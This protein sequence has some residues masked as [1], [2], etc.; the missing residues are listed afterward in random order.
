LII[1]NFAKYSFD[2]RIDYQFYNEFL[3]DIGGLEVEDFVLENIPDEDLSTD[4]WYEAVLEG[5]D[6]KYRVWISEDNSPDRSGISN[7]GL[8]IAEK[9]PLKIDSGYTKWRR[10]K[11]T[12]Y[13]GRNNLRF[14]IDVKEALEN[15]LPI[16]FQNKQT[17][18]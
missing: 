8:E 11:K 18:L 13:K 5:E 3:H 16:E 9:K 6:K 12:E 17:T 1:K 4:L 14:E 2:D 15:E 10:I 7:Y